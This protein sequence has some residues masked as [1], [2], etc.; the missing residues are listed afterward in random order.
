MCLLTAHVD[1]IATELI[2][3]VP[4]LIKEE[5]ENSISITTYADKVYQ[6]YE[7]ERHVFISLY[8]HKHTLPVLFCPKP[9][10]AIS[11]VIYCC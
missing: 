6:K 7:G 10:H 9:Y 8:T 1:L 4:T 3:P 5:E 11:R 2:H